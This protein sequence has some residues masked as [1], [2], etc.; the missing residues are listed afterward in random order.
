MKRGDHGTVKG[1]A[2]A[3][4]IALAITMALPGRAQAQAQ[5]KPIMPIEIDMSVFAA[6]NPFLEPDDD[7]VTGG[8][9]VSV[10]GR[11]DWQLAPGT[12]LDADGRVA[13]RQYTRRYGN[14]VTGRAALALNHRHNEYLT[15]L[16]EASFER[17]LPTETMVNSIDSAIDPI[18]LED[19]Y[20]LSQTITWH[21]DA[22]TTVNGR[23]GWSKLDPQGSSLLERTTAINLNVDA[24]RQIDALTT[25][26]AVGMMTWSRTQTGGNPHA[27][28]LLFTADRRIIDSW[29][30]QAQAGI[31]RT[32]Q[33]DAIGVRRTGGVQFAGNASL[34]HDPGRF[35]ACLTASIQPIV[36]AYGGILRET[37]Y[38]ATLSWRTSQ[39]GTLTA[40]A[41]YRRSPQ[42]P[43]D[44][45]INTTQ[46]AA[47]YDFRLNQQFTLYAGPEYNRRTGL[48]GQKVDSTVFQIGVTIGLPRP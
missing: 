37:A 44:R 41:D 16:T 39:R 20:N 12:D 31:S 32:S 8:A 17:L 1:S 43:P 2:S 40:S 45:A 10:R 6:R 13:F 46:L 7:V 14:F 36:S 48:S 28:S 33:V 34:C 18:S 47:R 15:L 11:T 29:R 27:W 5:P 42:P 22:L 21:S 24:K 26:G 4:A 35:T 38:G 9:V 25:L 19:N 30:L 23:L 3:I